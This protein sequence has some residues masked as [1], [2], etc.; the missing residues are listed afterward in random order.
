MKDV[1]FD[2]FQNTVND[3]LIRHKSILDI[4]TK[5]QESNGRINRAVAK[6]ITSCGCINVNAKKQQIPED[7]DDINIESLK[8]CLKTHIDGNLCDNCREVIEREIGN[9]LFYLT[10][11]CNILDLNLYDILIKEYDKINTLGKY[12]FR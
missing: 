9:N 10:S 6:S 5:F 11:L 3:S 4:I 12:T 1:I 7:N 2:D 8:N